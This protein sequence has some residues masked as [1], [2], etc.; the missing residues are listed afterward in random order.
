MKMP[1]T[2]DA[3]DKTLIRLQRIANQLIILIEL[4]LIGKTVFNVSSAWRPKTFRLTL[5]QPTK[6]HVVSSFVFNKK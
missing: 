6:T 1:S 4:F 5:I 2:M 3:M